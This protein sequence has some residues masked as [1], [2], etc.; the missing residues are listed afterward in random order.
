[1][2]REGMPREPVRLERSGGAV[3]LGCIW[4]SLDALDVQSRAARKR[5]GSLTLAPACTIS[6]ACPNLSAAT[7]HRG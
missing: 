4:L 7:G 3:P 1:M 6:S 5:A 2:F